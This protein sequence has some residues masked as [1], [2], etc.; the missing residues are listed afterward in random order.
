MAAIGPDRIT[1]RAAWLVETA[2]SP[3]ASKVDT[4]AA[5]SCSAAP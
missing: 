2:F 5:I 4:T 3:S 1:V